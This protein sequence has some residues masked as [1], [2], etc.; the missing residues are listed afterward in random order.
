MEIYTRLSRPD[1]YTVE[2]S[3]I[4]HLKAECFDIL[5]GDDQRIGFPDSR[6]RTRVQDK[7]ED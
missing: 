1:I 4:Q 2:G 5:E 3:R 6:H 7:A